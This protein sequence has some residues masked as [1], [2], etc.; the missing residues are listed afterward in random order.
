MWELRSSLWKCRPSPRLPHS[1]GDAAPAF[2][3]LE[4]KKKAFGDLSR[5][6]SLPSG[7]DLQ[8]ATKMFSLPHSLITPNSAS[9]SR[10]HLPSPFHGAVPGRSQRRSSTTTRRSWRLPLLSYLPSLPSVSLPV[11]FSVSL[12]L[13][14]LFMLLGIKKPQS[15]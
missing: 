10:L 7:S 11:P 8:P 5:S 1:A 14:L 13:L 9:V 2:G 15:L 6:Q 12:L 3:D 4:F